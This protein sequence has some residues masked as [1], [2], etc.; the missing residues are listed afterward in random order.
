MELF[1]SILH[2]EISVLAEDGGKIVG[3]STNFIFERGWVDPP[4]TFKDYCWNLPRTHAY[5]MVLSD[6]LWH[7]NDVFKQY[8]DVNKI[9]FFHSLAVDP[10]YRRNGIAKKLVQKGLE[11]CIAFF[12]LT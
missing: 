7:P 5:L 6:R 11:V 3:I 12:V 2:Q 9:F 10:E 8:P 4:K 1:Y